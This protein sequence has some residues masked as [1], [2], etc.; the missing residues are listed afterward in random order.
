MWLLLK[1]KIVYVGLIQIRRAE[2]SSQ[3]VGGDS[4]S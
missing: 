4:V 2:A 3:A 1:A